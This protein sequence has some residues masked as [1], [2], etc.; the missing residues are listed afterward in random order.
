[1]GRGLRGGLATTARHDGDVGTRNAF[2]FV[3]GLRVVIV[4][5]LSAQVLPPFCFVC[6]VLSGHLVFCYDEIG[7]FR[8]TRSL[9]LRARALRSISAD[10][11]S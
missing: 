10:V 5:D 2:A 11:G 4:C 6:G 1:M 7:S 9:A 3:R 8:A